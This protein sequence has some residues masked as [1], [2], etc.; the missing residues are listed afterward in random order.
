MPVAANTGSESG[1]GRIVADSTPGINPQT[2]SP[3][4]LS[5]A[6]AKTSAMPHDVA[7]GAWPSNRQPPST[8]VAVMAR[9]SMRRRWAKATPAIVRAGAQLRQERVAKLGV[10]RRSNGAHDAVMLHPGEERRT[11]AAADRRD[12][13]PCITRLQVEVSEF[14]RP[15]DAE[16]P[17][18]GQRVEPAARDELGAI[19][20]LCVGE[21]VL[22]RDACRGREHGVIRRRC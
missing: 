12:H 3:A 13:P 17:G 16:Q 5:A 4:S 9:R 21:Q 15:S 6:T 7:Q 19:D 11:T 18:L 20:L 1:V 14:G 8:G 10:G 22:V 2:T